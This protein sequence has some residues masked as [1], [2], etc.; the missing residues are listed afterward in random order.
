[1]LASPFMDGETEA[2]QAARSLAQALT[3]WKRDIRT[4]MKHSQ[5]LHVHYGSAVLAGCVMTMYTVSTDT[6]GRGHPA[7]PRSVGTNAACGDED[8]ESAGAGSC[9]GPPSVAS[10]LP[11]TWATWTGVSLLP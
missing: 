4:D 2:L 1:M 3:A 7:A 8:R 6:E 9:L 11:S 10:C 5:S